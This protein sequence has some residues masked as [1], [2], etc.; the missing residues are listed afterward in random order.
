MN[1]KGC[2]SYNEKTAETEE[3][4]YELDTIPDKGYI[5][6]ADLWY[7]VVNELPTKYKDSFKNTKNLYTKWFDYDKIKANLVLRTRKPGDVIHID[8]KGHTKK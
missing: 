5:Q 7:T 8:S 3:F 6:K 4:F 2:C 1:I